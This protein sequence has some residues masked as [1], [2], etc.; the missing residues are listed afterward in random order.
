M[1]ALSLGNRLAEEINQRVGIL[2]GV[3]VFIFFCALS[4][5]CHFHYKKVN[6]KLEDDFVEPSDKEKDAFINESLEDAENDLIEP[7][8]HA[9][10]RST[11]QS[12]SA[13]LF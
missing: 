7:S 6:N 1:C 2:V 12:P 4:G 9:I 8:D 5:L 3:G 10:E 11:P 13:G